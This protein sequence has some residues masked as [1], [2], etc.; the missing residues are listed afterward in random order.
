MW[1]PKSIKAM[2]KDLKQMVKDFGDKYGV[3]VDIG[4]ITFT[5]TT[6]TNMAN[7]AKVSKTENSLGVKSAITIRPK[8]DYNY[9][10]DELAA[11]KRF[12]NNVEFKYFLE[13]HKLTD[14]NGFDLGDEITIN[15]KKI[16]KDCSNRYSRDMS[17]IIVRQYPRQTFDGTDNYIKIKLVGINNKKR[18][19]PIIIEHQ[20]YNNKDENIT[21]KYS[22]DMS[23]YCGE[24][25][26]TLQFGLTEFLD[27]F[28]EQMITELKLDKLGL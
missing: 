28:D 21:N 26:Y 3:V 15:S 25:S 9:S 19:D 10:K 13:K 17:S 2:D 16:E 6:Y 23:E 18:N 22:Q 7:I 27:L 14:I 1:T 11:W 24:P 8:H 5:G 4:H 12:K 20:L